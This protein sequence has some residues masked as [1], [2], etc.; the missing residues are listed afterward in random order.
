MGNFCQHLENY[1]GH[2]CVKLASC[3]NWVIEESDR[4]IDFYVKVFL[5]NEKCSVICVFIHDMALRSRS[6]NF[7]ALSVTAAFLCTLWA[8]MLRV[9]REKLLTYVILLLYNHWQGLI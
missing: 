8:I 5:K 2:S 9:R 1:F 6:S 4:K 7:L 3:G